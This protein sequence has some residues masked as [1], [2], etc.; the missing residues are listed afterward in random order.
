MILQEAEL[1]WWPGPEP[2][3]HLSALAVS[4]AALLQRQVRRCLFILGWSAMSC[5]AASSLGAGWDEKN[6][7]EAHPLILFWGFIHSSI[8]YMPG[9][10]IGKGHARMLELMEG[11]EEVD[12]WAQ[13]LVVLKGPS[14]P[15]LPGKKTK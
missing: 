12:P 7:L 11:G 8:P 1:D 5:S 3:G 10:A 6:V 14:Y 13:C 4:A 9:A 15:R 2:L